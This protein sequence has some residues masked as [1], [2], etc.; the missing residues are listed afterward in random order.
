MLRSD[1]L[2]QQAP[3]WVEDEDVGHSKVGP[4]CQG[5]GPRDGP[6]HVVRFVDL[7]EEQLQATGH[8]ATS[9]TGPVWA[10]MTIP[11]LRPAEGEVR[12]LQPQG[13]TPKYTSSYTTSGAGPPAQ[14][15]QFPSPTYK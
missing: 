15:H 1:S 3:C 5:V 11:N 8:S 2:E 7:I 12:G 6:D 13:W 10:Y 4:A 14:S 9:V